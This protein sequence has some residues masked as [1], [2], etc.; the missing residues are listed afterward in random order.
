MTALFGTDGVRGRANELLTPELIVR[1]ARATAKHIGGRTGSA[2]IGRDTRTSGPMLEAALAAGLAS[3]GIDVFLAGVIPTPAISY[4]IK[5]ERADFGAVVSASHNPPSDNG[6][7]LFDKRGMKLSIESERAI[8][9]LLGRDLP[10]AQRVGGIRRLEAAATRYAAFLS[11]TIDVESI[12]LSEHR[13]AVDCAYGATGRIAPRVL[14][15]LGAEVIELHT[16]PDGTR[17]NQNCGSTH[18]DAVRAAVAEHGAD[19]GIAFDGD[20]DR[21]LLVTPSGQTI[22]GDRMMGIVALHM[23]RRGTLSPRTVVATVMSN[24]GLER[25]LGENGIELHRTPVGD[26]N[27]SQTLFSEG[28]Q[29]G[30]EQS[31]HLIFA[32]HSPTGDGILTAVKLLEIAHEAG[33]SLEAL[34]NEIPVYPQI[35]RTFACAD[36]AAVLASP[37]VQAVLEAAEA[38][39]GARGRVIARPSGTQPL[40]RVTVEAESDVLCAETSQR[41]AET[42]EGHL[43]QNA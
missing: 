16:Q 40:L 32:D 38:Q 21:V 1:L 24:L 35:H 29:L 34:A 30:G 41:L 27:V 14:R 23:Q 19:L 15:H 3:A 7:K 17:I 39:L 22:D 4:L 42:V 18:L 2:I 10:A 26:R 20:G 31:G 11:G 12:D 6:I 5:D 28:A 43:A 33:A 37:A 25:V 8:E 13:L 36:P 9:A